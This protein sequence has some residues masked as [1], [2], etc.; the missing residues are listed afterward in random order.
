VELYSG[1]DRSALARVATAPLRGAR[2]EAGQID[3]K[4]LEPAKIAQGNFRP[5]FAMIGER[6]GIGASGSNGRAGNINLWHR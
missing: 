2:R 6:A 1:V 4:L 5:A 3:A